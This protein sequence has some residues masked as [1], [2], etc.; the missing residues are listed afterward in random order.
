MTKHI[1]NLGQES[2]ILRDVPHTDH[3]N[4]RIVDDLKRQI[5]E[6]EGDDEPYREL[7]ARYYP[8][9]LLFC[10]SCLLKA[11]EPTFSYQLATNT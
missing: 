5:E 8:R 11:D 6:A 2:E 9:G 4:P 10:N 3:F 1:Q 7:K